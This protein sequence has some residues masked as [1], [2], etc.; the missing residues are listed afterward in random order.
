MTRQ[1]LLVLALVLA[2]CECGP[3]ITCTTD[4]DCPSWGRCELGAAPR[5]ACVQRPIEDGG[6][7]GGADAGTDA[8]PDAGVDAGVPL[9]ALSAAAL[10]VPLAGCGAST[11]AVLTVT[12]AGS[13]P[14]TMTASTGTSALFS[15]APL[16]G[17]VPAGQAL[18]LTVTATVP[19]TA[20]AGTEFQGMLALT[21]NDAAGRIDVP[22]TARATGVTLTLTPSVA[23]FGLLPVSSSA[24]PLPLTLTN[25]GNLAATLTLAPP[26][27]PQFSLQF[28]GMPAAVTLAPGASV[29]GLQ[30]RFGAARAGPSSSSAALSVAEPTCG[31]SVSSIPLTG[32]GTNGGV[33]LS[34]TDVFF[35]ANGR[36]DCGARAADRTFTLTNTGNQAYAWTGTLARG[37]ASP[38]T[39]APTSGTVP[40]NGGSVLITVSSTAIPAQA[41]T[42]DDAFGDTFTIVTDVANDVSHPISL[43][44]TAN[45]AIL[46][47]APTAVDFGQVPVNNTASAPFSVVNDGNTSPLVTLTSDNVKFTLNPA[48]PLVAPGG[49]TT[50]LTGTYAP[51]S[52]VMPEAAQVLLSLDGGEP[53][54]APLP[55]ALALTGEGT[56]GSVSY[57]PVALD[58][59][60]VNCGATPGARTVTFRNNG[61]QAYTV[62]PVLGRDAGSP[63]VV[64]MSPASGVVVTDGGTLII[65]VAPRALPQTSPVTPNLYGDTLTVTTDVPSDSPHNIPL[66][67]TA[68]GTIFAISA[69]TLD[70]GSVAVG[71]SASAQFTVSNSGNAPGALVFTPIAPAVF[72]MPANALVDAASSS[73]ENATF[74]PAAQT[75]YSDMAAVSKTAATV[76]CQPLPFATVALAGVGTAANLVALSSSSLNFGLVPCG[77]TAPAQ[78]LT[79]TNNSSNQLAFTFSLAGGAASPYT[80]SGPASVPAGGMG[81]VTVTPKVVPGT[82]STAPDG[83]AD[84]LSITAIGGPVNEAHTVALHQTAQGAVL[85]LNPTSLSFN[86]GLGGSQTKSFTVNNAGNLAAPYSLALGG[87]N[88]SSFTV[89]PTSGTA[90]GGGSVS[91]SATFNAP[92]LGGSRSA[93]LTLSTSAG[94]CAPLPAPLPLSGTTN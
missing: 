47:F 46:S 64:T 72:G 50:A 58:F 73:V 84:T 10:D 14:L 34:T 20:M 83:F 70:F 23:S 18:V 79:V 30:A 13:A 94:R 45:G 57:S 16:S 4:S 89:T 92:L 17:T 77:N 74:S 87:A 44:Q 59:G 38:F 76:L 35:G 49:V 90:S 86:T 5:G 68:R 7:D 62:T 78:T 82:S 12:N 28:T 24:P 75:T 65:T 22:L 31:A 33:G 37:G 25:A 27:D 71:V 11:S 19:A 29:D 26:A 2:G 1:P 21:T 56:S 9:A 61:N 88:P 39:V 6:L 52:A 66:R 8:G 43:H 36:V 15:V 3:G 60:Q 91:E 93:T 80:V 51:G 85:S 67:L 40:A 63:Y 69:S 48:T 81:T 42:S 53:L 41:L 32:Q 54:C 55:Q